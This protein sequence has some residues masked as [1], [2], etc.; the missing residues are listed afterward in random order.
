MVSCREYFSY[1]RELYQQLK[2]KFLGDGMPYIGLRGSWYDIV[3]NAHT[4][5]KDKSD[6]SRDSSCE[7][8]EQV[9]DHFPK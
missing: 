1:V 6:V 5:V 2:V 7:E 9:W 3:L 8:L 4:S